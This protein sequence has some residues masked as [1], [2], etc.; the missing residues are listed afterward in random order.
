M[1]IAIDNKTYDPYFILDVTK[2]DT[3]EFVTKS[4][5]RKAKMWHPDKNQDPTKVQYYQHMFKVILE[6][7]KFILSEKNKSNFKH[8]NREEITVNKSHS[9]PTKS[10]DNSGELN[11]FNTEFEKLRVDAPN[12][13]GYTAERMKDAKDYENFKYKP[14]K[15]FDTKQFNPNDFNKAFEF[16]QTNQETS[17][18]VGLYYQT[19][20]GFNAYNGGDMGGASV[21]SY[22]GVMIVGDNFGQNGQGY[23]DSNYSDYQHTFSSAKNPV[24]K[25]KIPSDFKAQ[26]NKQVEALSISESKRQIELQKQNRSIKVEEGSSKYNFQK[27]EELLLKKQQV[28]IKQK[29]NQDKELILQY[30]HMYSDQN[31]IDS[32]ISGNLIAS[33]DYVT[34]DN[35]N[36]RFLKTKF[37]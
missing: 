36:K 33:S 10:L 22:N 30:R 12:D 20:D 21:S 34:E 1:E 32:A 25:L 6:S 8:K 31:T 14:H 28:Q 35:I 18:D 26:A 9:I 3:E 29:I 7:Y 5:R 13:F 16:N 15:L 11:I 2:K 23:Y 37:N 17:G 24:K 19:T 4:F 27:Q